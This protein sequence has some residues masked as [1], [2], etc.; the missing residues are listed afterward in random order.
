MTRNTRLTEGVKRPVWPVQTGFSHI[1]VN[2]AKLFE[3]P[4]GANPP[5]TDYKNVRSFYEKSAPNFSTHFLG[6]HRH[7]RRGRKCQD[8][9]GTAA[10]EQ[11]GWFCAGGDRYSDNGSAFAG[12]RQ[13]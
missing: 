1:I 3:E 9:K 10:G 13:M 4:I 6:K 8:D 12:I 5:H 2:M 11:D 7:R